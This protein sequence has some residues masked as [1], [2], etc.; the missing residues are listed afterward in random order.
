MGMQQFSLHQLHDSGLLNRLASEAVAGGGYDVQLEI[1]AEPNAKAD[2]LFKSRILGKVSESMWIVEH[3][4]DLQG[5]IVPVRENQAISV[6]HF[7][8]KTAKKF[9]S[10]VSK[11]LFSPVPLLFLTV[12]ADSRL[13]QLT[14]RA[15]ER[16][17]VNTPATIGFGSKDRP[18]QTNCV[19]ADISTN[20]ALLVCPALD[21]KDSPLQ[22]RFAVTYKEVSH[23]VTL[24][25]RI[26]RAQSEQLAN[27]LHV[28]K[29]GVSFESSHIELL[30]DLLLSHLVS[31]LMQK[32]SL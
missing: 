9:I 30:D 18:V 20:G 26:R 1:Q 31:S 21:L 2:R 32:K 4:K 23:V 6:K 16:V 24:P 19:V 13:V 7:D 17:V 3:P 10:E 5:A 12:P 28:Q 8:G 22:L 15:A 25:C 11:V 29:V 27:G 14:L